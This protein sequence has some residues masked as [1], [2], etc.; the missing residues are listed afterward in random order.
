[1]CDMGLLWIDT[2]P[3]FGLKDHP[4]TAPAVD[5]PIANLSQFCEERGDA[6]LLVGKSLL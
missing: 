4:E 6:C 1:M 5:D 3:A 2:E